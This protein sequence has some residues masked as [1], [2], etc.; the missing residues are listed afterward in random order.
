MNIIIS[1]ELCTKQTAVDEDPL[2]KTP[3]YGKCAW[4][5]S[6]GRGGGANIQG[7]RS[8]GKSLAGGGG[9]KSSGQNPVPFYYII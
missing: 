7:Q 6:P 9:Q 4:G 2:G 5:K 1:K 8:G 3:T